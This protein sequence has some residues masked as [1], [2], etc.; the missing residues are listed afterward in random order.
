MPDYSSEQLL[1]A[2]NERL[3]AEN[4]RLRTVVEGSAHAIEAVLSDERVDLRPPDSIILRTVVRRLREVAP[5][6]D[7][8]EPMGDKAVSE[9][10]PRVVRSREA[11]A[12]HREGRPVS[13]NHATGEW[14]IGEA[15]AVAGHTCPTCG[16]FT[17]I[18]DLTPKSPCPWCHGSGRR[19]LTDDELDRIALRAAQLRT[20]SWRN[21]TGPGMTECDVCGDISNSEPNLPC[22]RIDYADEDAPVSGPC[23]GTYRTP[24]RPD[25]PPALTIPVDAAITVVGFN[26]DANLPPHHVAPGEGIEG[27]LRRTGTCDHRNLEPGPL[28]SGLPVRCADCG[29]T[30]GD[31]S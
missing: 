1:L 3:W 16:S 31:D 13:L 11:L 10:D 8:S 20:E 17:P 15:G 29:E 19:A 24:G 21:A 7:I 14:T 25:R 28:P 30:V 12:A 18:G 2:E 5:G 4:K 22:G 9:D 23:Q 27:Y 6:L 26:A